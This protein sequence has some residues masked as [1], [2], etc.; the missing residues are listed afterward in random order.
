VIFFKLH[1]FSISLS[2]N[3]KTDLKVGFEDFK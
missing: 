2:G 3:K 1:K